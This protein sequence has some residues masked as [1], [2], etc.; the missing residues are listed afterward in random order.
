MHERLIS[1]ASTIRNVVENLVNSVRVEEK[2]NR[3]ES[4]RRLRWIP[5]RWMGGKEGQRKG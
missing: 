5:T 2:I 4:K 1:A 3:V